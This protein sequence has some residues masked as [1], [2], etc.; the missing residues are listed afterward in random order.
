MDPNPLSQAQYNEF[1]RE[2]AFELI[3]MP[4]KLQVYDQ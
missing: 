1:L 4:R 3:A 2:W